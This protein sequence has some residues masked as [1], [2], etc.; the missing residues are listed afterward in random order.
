MAMQVARLIPLHESAVPY[1]YL[2]PQEG[3]VTIGRRGTCTVILTDGAVSGLHCA[4]RCSALEPLTFVVEDKSSNGTFINEKRVMKGSTASLVRGDILS[5]GKAVEDHGGVSPNSVR[6]QFR[7][8]AQEQERSAEMLGQPSIASRDLRSDATSIDRC[9]PFGVGDKHEPHV[10]EEAA[11]VVRVSSEVSTKNAEGFAQ[12]LLVLEQ[13]SK[14]KITAELLLVRRRLDEERSSREALDRDLRKARALLEDERSRRASAQEVLARLQ[15]EADK[16]RHEHREMIELK[17]DHAA[18]ETK[19]EAAE[20]ELGALLQRATSLEAGQEHIRVDCQRAAADEMRVKAQMTEAQTRL[21][22]AQE[23]IDV[24]QKRQL[25]ARRSVEVGQESVE[26]WQRELNNERATREQLEDQVALLNAD[27]D[28]ASHGEIAAKDALTAALAQQREIEAQLVKYS[29]ESTMDRSKAKETRDIL[30][31]DS[32]QVERVVAAGDRFVNALRTYA[33]SWLRGLLESGQPLAIASSSRRETKIEPPSDLSET[34]V[35]AEAI[36]NPEK[37][38]KIEPPTNE[39]VAVTDAQELQLAGAH[40]AGV[41]GVI[42]IKGQ[43][44][45]MEQVANE[46]DTNATFRAAPLATEALPAAALS[47]AGED[48]IRPPVPVWDPKAAPDVV[49]D[50]SEVALRGNRMASMMVGSQDSPPQKDMQ[51]K[52]E[53]QSRSPIR[54]CREVT[55]HL[56]KRD[57]TIMDADAMQRMA[58]TSI[59]TLMPTPAKRLVQPARPSVGRKRARNN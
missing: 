11:A 40:P 49:G 45:A 19:H 52:D 1:Y 46:D 43:Q 51:P 54:A 53:S 59:L 39:F 25:E 27:L 24:S 42:D 26:R 58:S 5:L 37:E 35:G 36:Q 8:E 15:S 18:L 48:S 21:Q 28:R 14:A 34:K 29:V 23:R 47:T 41:A 17:Q 9:E 6:T 4:L 30:D 7:L 44:A 56:P 12:D 22:Q 57:A 33:D 20:V 31:N 10:L 13:R 16:R 32:K 50:Q 38:S 55:N 3:S 2:L